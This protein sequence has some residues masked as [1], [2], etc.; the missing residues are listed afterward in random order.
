M[1]AASGVCVAISGQHIRRENPK[2]DQVGKQESADGGTD[3]VSGGHGVMKSLDGDGP[4]NH[5]Q[6]DHGDEGL[7][8]HTGGKGEFSK[9]A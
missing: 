2:M 7:P 4:C 8:K 9:H 3:V 1:V 6:Q 5:G